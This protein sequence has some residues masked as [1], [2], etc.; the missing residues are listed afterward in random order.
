MVKR[1]TRLGP[2]VRYEVTIPFNG[3][4]VTG[5]YTLQGNIITVTDA[6]GHSKTMQS[7]E[8][9]IETLAKMLLRELV[10]TRG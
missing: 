6:S 2:P 4:V 3:G 10:N 5:H 1:R 7:N 9:P 8:T